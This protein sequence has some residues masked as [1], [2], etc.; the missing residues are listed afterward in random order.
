M[1]FTNT[2]NGPTLLP[3][4][5]DAQEMCQGQPGTGHQAPEYG[6]LGIGAAGTCRFD[7]QGFA[8]WSQASRSISI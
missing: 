3:G 4:A 2:A 5:G 1:V 8:L 6:R 7:A